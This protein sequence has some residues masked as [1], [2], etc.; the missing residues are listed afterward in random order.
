MILPGLR[1]W[2]KKN[3]WKIDRNI[4]YGTYNEYLFSAF[5]GSGYKAFSIHLPVLEEAKRIQI[6]DFI[7]ENKKK[8]RISE[9][10]FNDNILIVKYRESYWSMGIKDMKRILDALTLKFKELEIPDSSH[11]VLC[12]TADNSSIYVMNDKVSVVMCNS[13]YQKFADEIEE[14]HR[15][16]SQN[17][18]NYFTGF[19]GALVGG[20]IASIG[21]VLAG[22]FLNITA[23]ILGYLIGIS[24]LKG[25]KIMRGKIGKGTR[26]ILS[27][28][29]LFCII[30]SE[31]VVLSV[32]MY[33]AGAALIPYNYI[34]LLTDSGAAGEILMNIGLG[35][36]FGFLG[37]WPLLRKLKN[38]T[39]ELL[40][41][42][43][44]LEM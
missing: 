38:D 21:W 16:Y 12:G 41:Q 37:I 1:N 11:C 43:R 5:E 24:A 9:Y 27:L 8:I 25:Y 34:L 36:L 6:D 2:A 10:I 20:C 44:K 3:N 42:I 29:M 31:F 35:L 32:I 33:R 28:V 19:I 23:S 39:D 40:P 13:C 4:I 17:E 15:E 18:K 30:A 7:K 22:V 26:I 14:A